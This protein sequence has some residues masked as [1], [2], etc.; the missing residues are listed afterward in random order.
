MSF[1]QFPLRKGIDGC[2]SFLILV[3]LGLIFLGNNFLSQ[4][5]IY[6]IF[7]YYKTIAICTCSYF[8]L[9]RFI[10]KSIRRDNVIEHVTITNGNLVSFQNIS[11]ILILVYNF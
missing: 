1:L 6:I 11:F 10:H 2:I 3:F 9:R 8:L 5:N 4:D 7:D